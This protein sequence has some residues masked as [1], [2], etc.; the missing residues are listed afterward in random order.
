MHGMNRTT[1]SPLSGDDHLAQ[2]IGD[3]LSTPIGTRVMLRDYGSRLFDL[4]DQPLNSI[5]RLKFI[6]ATVDALRRWEPRLRVTRVLLSASD[7]SGSAA[8]T[9]EGERLD[10]PGKPLTRLAIPLT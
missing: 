5:T 3:I 4:I 9:I 10:Q 2:S 6:A 7:A 8:I 1:G